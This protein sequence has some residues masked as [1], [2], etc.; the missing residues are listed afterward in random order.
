VP[1]LKG[2][3][4]FA[5]YFIDKIVIAIPPLFVMGIP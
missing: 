2:I 5:E 3:L 1:F 4:L